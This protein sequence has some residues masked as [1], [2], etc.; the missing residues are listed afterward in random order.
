[1]A[2]DNF[3]PQIWANRILENLNAAHVFADRL[4]RDYEGDIKAAGDSVR[5][6]SIGRVTISDY[7]KN[8]AITAPETLQGSDMV[9]EITQAKYF[10][11]EID[12]IDKWQQKPKLMDAATRE[13]AWSMADA[14][15]TYLA[16]VLQAG[17]TNNVTGGGGAVLTIGTAAL[18]TNAYVALVNA[19]VALTEQNVPTRGR[20]AVIPPWMEGMLLKDDRFVSYGTVANRDDLKNGNIG[21]AAGFDIF[22]SNNLSSLAGAGVNYYIQTGVNESATYAEQID[23]TE[24]FRPEG[25][26]SDALKGLHLYGAKVTRPYGLCY[27][28][29]TEGT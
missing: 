7:V 3:I 13:T 21:R 8:G 19:G 18:E 28:Y 14:V 12:D 16:G 24:A 4:N 29:G 9:L 15:D 22:V 25:S 11:F 27:I 20:W 2:I 6:N 10:N 17:S 26:F 1:M 23:D 5:I